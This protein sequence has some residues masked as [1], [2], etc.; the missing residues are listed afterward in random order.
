MAHAETKQIVTGSEIQKVVYERKD[1]FLFKWWKK[2]SVTTVGYEI[3]IITDEP[4]L[5][6]V[7]LNN[8]EIY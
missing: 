4:N 2:V 7:R 1:W 6:S 3:D 5:K 8:V